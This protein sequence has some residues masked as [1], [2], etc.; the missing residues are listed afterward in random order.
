[1]LL[2]LLVQD[3]LVDFVRA[4]SKTAQKHWISI[5]VMQQ[6]LNDYLNAF[7]F[8]RNVSNI[9]PQFIIYCM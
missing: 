7:K 6:W 4:M 8:I 9:E 5:N 1:M 3:K 2:L